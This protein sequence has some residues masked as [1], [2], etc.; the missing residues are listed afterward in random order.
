MNFIKINKVSKTEEVIEY[1]KNQILT[2]NLRPGEKLPV[3]EALAENMGVGRGTI[4]EALR[5]LIHLGLIERNSSGTYVTESTTQ[6]ATHIEPY[7]YRDIIE[8]M[9]VRRVIEPA[10]A[11]MATV[12]G[13]RVL[14]DRL[15]EELAEMRS[16]VEDPDSF[17]S[18]DHLFHDLISQAAGN[19]LFRNFLSSFEDLMSK[20]QEVVLKERFN[21]IMPKSLGF[22]ER[23]YE[24]INSGDKEGAF[25]YMKRHI[26]D[27]ESEFAI[28]AKNEKG[29]G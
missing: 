21:H 22:H 28:I 7:V 23:I 29:E 20:N 4:R 27:V 12:R 10:L 2:R 19:Y 3:E 14:I 6:A 17:L 1:L 15:G 11:E 25:L 16:K 9:E 8:V 13:D 26:D 5:V 24:S 18:H